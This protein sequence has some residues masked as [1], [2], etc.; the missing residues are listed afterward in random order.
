MGLSPALLAQRI[1]NQGGPSHGFIFDG[2]LAQSKASCD[3]LLRHTFYFP[4]LN[5]LPAKRRQTAY[6]ST[7]LLQFTRCT[8]DAFWRGLFTTDGQLAH[9]PHTVDTNNACPADL[10][11]VQVSH[12]L[13]KISV[14]PIDV[15]DFF[16]AGDFAI[17][18]LNEIIDVFR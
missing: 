2:T 7:H 8:N 1:H 10:I 14:R 18:F 9:L 15:I 3:F 17:G 16:Q 12:N 4:K 13:K 5:H 11:T 6:Q